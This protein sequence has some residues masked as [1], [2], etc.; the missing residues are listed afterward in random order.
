MSIESAIKFYSE[1]T[2]NESRLAQ[3]ADLKGK[4]INEK[5]FNERILPVAKEKGYDFTYKE[6]V[7]ATSKGKELDNKDLENIAGGGVGNIETNINA[8]HF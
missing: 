3:F 2:K 1:I 5:V 8:C 7:R 6:L 4:D